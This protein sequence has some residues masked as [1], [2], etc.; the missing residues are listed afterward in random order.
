MAQRYEN[1]RKRRFIGI[2][3]DLSG[4]SAGEG[5]D[6]RIIVVATTI[7]ELVCYS[8]DMTN[9][10]NI[11]SIPNVGCLL[12]VA[13]QTEEAR[14][15]KALKDAGLDITTAEYLIMRLL[16]TNDVMQ[17]CEISRVLRKD[18]ASISRS[19]RSLERKGLAIVNQSSYKCCLV[20]LSERG[21]ALEPGIMEIAQ[22]LHAELASRIT[23][24][25]M[26]ILREILT[27]IIK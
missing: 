26:N 27:Q 2:Y 11:Y 4:L 15:A 17:Q 23:A 8:D 1:L 3:Q 25:E 5:N 13:Y 24:Q 6:F 14:L 9:E 19:I 20:S 7:F 10:Q 21:R 12:G 16:L 22:R 18:R